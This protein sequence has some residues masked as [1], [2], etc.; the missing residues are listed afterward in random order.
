MT[1]F[2][3]IS[4]LTQVCCCAGFLLDF[5][6]PDA[7]PA[8]TGGSIAIY[9]DD[10]ATPFTLSCLFNGI[11]SVPA[12]LALYRYYIQCLARYAPAIQLGKNQRSAKHSCSS[13][14]VL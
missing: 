7:V 5:I 1:S 6:Y 9:G 4:A 13:E 11:N 12:E 3:L 8:D 10:L 14:L 2:V